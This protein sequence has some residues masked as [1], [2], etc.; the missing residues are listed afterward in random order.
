MSVGKYQLV[1][2]NQVIARERERKIRMGILS[3][4]VLTSFTIL[5]AYTLLISGA[6][7]KIQNAADLS[8]PQQGAN[9][10]QKRPTVWL[11]TLPVRRLKPLA[12]YRRDYQP[13]VEFL[14]DAPNDIEKRFGERKLI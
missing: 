13:D 3:V 8:S 1:S 14:D 5:M 10:L 9:E 6:S 4:S 7:A 11:K 12:L 2:E